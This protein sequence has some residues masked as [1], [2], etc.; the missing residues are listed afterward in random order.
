MPIKHRTVK[1][2]LQKCTYFFDANRAFLKYY[3]KI[4]RT[5]HERIV[6]L[7]ITPSKIVQYALNWAS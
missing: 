5:G 2:S 3:S 6:L 1:T 4:M 7:A